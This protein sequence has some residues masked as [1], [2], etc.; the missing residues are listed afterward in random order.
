MGKT[1]PK[2]SCQ[3]FGDSCEPH[4]QLFQGLSPSCFLRVRREPHKFDSPSL[5]H[6]CKQFLTCGWCSEG[7]AEANLPCRGSLDALHL[8]P[9]RGMVTDKVVATSTRTVLSGEP[10]LSSPQ[11]G[12][13]RTM[14]FCSF[15]N[16]VN[17][18]P[19]D[20]PRVDPKLQP[21]CK[22][23]AKWKTG[24]SSGQRSR[25]ATCSRL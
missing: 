10:Q 24:S 4:I 23:R 25:A 13:P 7:R 22:L 18:Y 15:W 3:V 6:C 11:R 16:S 19:T 8:A 1:S 2:T 5:E 14:C 21:G 9:Y 20:V 17:T 12:A